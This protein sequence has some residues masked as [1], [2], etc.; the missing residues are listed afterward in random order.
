VRKSMAVSTREESR[1]PE[2]L[3][4]VHTIAAPAPRADLAPNVVAD[5][6]RGDQQA[7]AALV[8]HY[9]RGLRSLAFR[10][11]GDRDRMD[12][13][14]QE[15]YVKA[16]RALPKFRG[17]AGLGTW[18][19][20]ITYN[21]CIDELRRPHNAGDVPLDD[22]PGSRSLEPDI[23]DRVGERNALARALAALPVEDRAAV[24]LVDG[25][26][27]DYASA[28]RVLGVPAGT[29]ASRLNRARATLRRAL[30]GVP[31]GVGD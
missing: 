5:A 2:R 28:S 31:E 15:A 30:A 25:E 19:Y 20:R 18:L 7:F 27:F 14:L 12:D 29:V 22:V 26:G 9:D 23:A 21:A 24:L 6:K 8:R 3:R 16:Y 4:G 11:L 10:L 13:A 17:E 1:L